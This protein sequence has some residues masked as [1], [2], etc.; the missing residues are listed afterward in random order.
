MAG[1]QY[2]VD[3]ILR[4]PVCP[5]LVMDVR[6]FVG[7]DLTVRTAGGTLSVRGRLETGAANDADSGSGSSRASSARTL[8]RRF[9]LP[10]DAD[11]EKVESMLSRDAVLT[12][13]IPKRVSPIHQQGSHLPHRGRSPHN[14]NNC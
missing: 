4:A 11:G 7:G 9:N 3:G 13:T 12:V 5:Q 14:T 6:E 8:H 2:K 1:S 10:P